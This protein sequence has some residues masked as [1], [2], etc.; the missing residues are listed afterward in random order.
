LLDLF[1][2]S[3]FLLYNQHTLPVYAY[4]LQNR[5]RD[6]QDNQASSDRMNSGRSLGAFDGIER[7]E[8]ETKVDLLFSTEQIEHQICCRV[9]YE[10]SEDT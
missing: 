9:R 5:E 4:E 6:S 7:K 2:S 10:V 3:F 8:V 1:Y